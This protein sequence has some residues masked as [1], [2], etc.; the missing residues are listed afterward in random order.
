[1][2]S[3]LRGVGVA[4][5]VLVAGGG[6]T[7]MLCALGLARQGR[8]VVLCEAKSRL[9]Q[10]GDRL[11]A[12]NAPACRLLRDLGVWPAL[13]DVV[14]VRGMRVFAPGGTELAIDAARAG[15]A[16]LC[17]MVEEKDLLESLARATVHAQLAI[18]LGCQVERLTPGSREIM[19]AGAG[20]EIVARLAIGADGVN[21]AVARLA[22]LGRA[23]TTLSDSA[24]VAR[25]RLPS[26]QNVA[27]QWMRA[28]GILALLPGPRNMACVVWA[29]PHVQAVAVVNQADGEFHANLV[30]WCGAAVAGA[31]DLG[32]RRL[33]P[34]S[35]H[36][37]PMVASRVALVGD[38]AHGF[39]PLA[40]QGMAV[41]LG[42]VAGLLQD[43]RGGDP[44]RPGA[45]AKY[46]RGRGLRVWATKQLTGSLA[47]R[48]APTGWL[49]R[50]FSLPVG[51][52]LALL[53]N[54]P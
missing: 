25:V 48:P 6:P 35:E 39:H 40:G 18:Q 24:V 13:R 20:T 43:T 9:G 10:G 23:P 19:V 50:G 33:F 38:S 16:A 34:I 42:D 12:L 11:Y 26:L 4:V 2:I 3:I 28:D 44:G 21:S 46:R 51:N 32:A 37:R 8:Q 17:H 22:G 1:M 49:D 7:G 47:V 45:L 30:R 29:M 41:G 27:M 14:L 36:M 5:D 52:L 54:H 53:A 15:V 31:A